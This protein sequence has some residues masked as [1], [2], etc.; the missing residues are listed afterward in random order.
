MVS[1]SRVGGASVA[2]ESVDEGMRPGSGPL[3]WRKKMQANTGMEGGS[4]PSLV[5]KGGVRAAE[6]SG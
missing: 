1:L 4:L 6:V 2:A 5:A 3:F